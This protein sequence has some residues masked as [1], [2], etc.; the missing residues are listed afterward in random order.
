M[1][2]RVGVEGWKESQEERTRKKKKRRRGF[3]K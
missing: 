1:R 3:G 2:T